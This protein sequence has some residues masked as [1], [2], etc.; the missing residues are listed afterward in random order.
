[1]PIRKPKSTPKE[2]LLMLLKQKSSIPELQE[3]RD[4]CRDVFRLGGV[5]GLDEWIEARR[6]LNL[7]ADPML[8]RHADNLQCAIGSVI[9]VATVKP[10]STSSGPTW[11]ERLALLNQR[12]SCNRNN[13]PRVCYYCRLNTSARMQQGFDLMLDAAIA[14]VRRGAP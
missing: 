13:V 6:E 8:I 9:D 5:I 3:F 2:R 4:Q 14:M 10:Q 12:E 11:D 7:I 1:M